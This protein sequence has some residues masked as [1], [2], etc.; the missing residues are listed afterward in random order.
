M[1]AAFDRANLVSIGSADLVL[2]GRDSF[3]GF[4]SYWP[5]V[6]DAPAPQ[7]PDDPQ[8]RAVGETEPGHQPPVQRAAQGRGR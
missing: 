7:N 3:D 5:F 2:L 6:A 4:S 8:A 1:D